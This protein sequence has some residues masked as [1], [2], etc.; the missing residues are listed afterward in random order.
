M[1]DIKKVS[2]GKYFRVALTKSGKLFFQGVSRKYMLMSNGNRAERKDGFELIEENF[3]RNE[4]DD[5]LVDVVGGK[6]YTAVLT[7][8]GRIY[9]SSYIFWRNHEH[10]RSNPE[11][12]EDTPY[13]LKL[14]EGYSGKC[15]FGS[16]TN[17]IWVNA[18]DAEGK[19]KTLVSG[20]HQPEQG[21][22]YDD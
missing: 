21:A 17:M 22:A 5:K 19:I 16:F 15:L 9:A 12:Y 13:E 20:E 2:H 8:K 3:F 18:T 11:N 1:T 4:E 7:E 10:C 6:N 14:P